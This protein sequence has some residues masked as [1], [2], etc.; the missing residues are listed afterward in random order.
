MQILKT[1]SENKPYLGDVQKHAD[2]NR[3]ALGF[4]PASSY[5]EQARKGRLFVAITRKSKKYIGHLLYGGRYPSLKIFQIHVCNVDRKQKVGT[6]LLNELIQYG[7][8]KSFLSISAHVAADLKANLFWEKAG[9]ALVRQKKGGKSKN[10]IINIRVKNLNS[11]SILNYTRISQPPSSQSQDIKYSEKPLLNRPSYAIDLNVMFDLLKNR[12]HHDEAGKIFQ[13]GWSGDIKLCVTAEFR[14]E[15][16]RNKF[17]SSNDPIFKFAENLPALPEIAQKYLAPLIEEIGTLIFPDKKS[18]N[19]YSDQDKSDLIHLTSAIHHKIHGFITREDAILNQSDTLS[20]IYGLEILSPIDLLIDF[21]D[22]EMRDINFLN[23][24]V[25]DSRIQITN[26]SDEHRETVERVLVEAGIHQINISEILHPGTTSTKR[27]RKVVTFDQNV[28]GIASWEQ[29]NR[30]KV[31]TSLYLFIDE[32]LPFSNRVIDHILEYVGRV[33]EPQIVRKFNLN[34]GKSQTYT[35][36]AASLRGYCQC[37][38]DEGKIIPDRL[39]K[40]VY[41]GVINQNNWDSFKNS[42]RK[43]TNYSLPSIL[44]THQEFC[45]TGICIAN[46]ET[47]Q[48]QYVKLFDF[49]TLISPGIVFCPKRTSIILPIKRRYAEELLGN[50]SK[51]TKMFASAEALLHVEKAYFKKARNKE[52]FARGIPVFFYVSGK[53]NMKVIGVGRVTYSDYL[54]IEEIEINL[55]RQGVLPHSQLSGL[56]N[57]SKQIHAITFDNF[58]LL[59][60]PIPYSFLKNNKIISGANLVT[61]EMI[62]SKNTLILGKAAF[63]NN[64]SI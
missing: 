11:L 44:P 33:S 60:T 15:L 37:Y 58:N 31:E 16:E 49:E 59:Q 52:L 55:S 39:S 3:N 57:N 27:E 20:Q 5:E 19:R 8:S 40:I 12:K 26:F 7:E 2:N 45:H 54:S 28:I 50:F 47:Y 48:E 23:V 35:K 61:S 51:Q 53:G 30:F 1:Y 9:F 25:D 24:L 56:V 34:I 21:P 22:Y 13:A 43:L 29:F 41:R 64:T 4:L 36:Q 63:S 14:K 10:R 6:S 18:Q 38:S 17:K 62:S 46:D 42:F 32:K